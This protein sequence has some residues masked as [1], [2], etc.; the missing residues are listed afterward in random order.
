MNIKIASCAILMMAFGI[1]ASSTYADSSVWKISKDGK[2]FYLGGTMHLLNAQDHP[3]P[4]EFIKAYKDSDKLIFETNMADTKTPEAKQKFSSAMAYSAAKTLKHDLN[5]ET[6][7]KLEQFLAERKIPIENVARLKPWAVALMITMIE[8]Q[9]A[10]M[11]PEYGVEEY[12]NKLAMADNKALGY[13]E[14]IDEQ[15]AFL[16]SMEKIEPNMMIDYTIRDL[17]E[18]PQTVKS[19]KDSW[20][21]GDIDSLAINNS[22]AQMKTEFPEIYDALLVNRNNDWMSDL[23]AL[24]NNDTKEFVLVGALHL[25]GK[26]GLLN[27]LRLAGFKIDQL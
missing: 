12:F 9:K 15:I 1:L 25:S 23:S 16:E 4:K 22:I 6:Y 5:E 2:Y 3:L 17:D 11:M 13:L 19:L 24:N 14:S 7:L 18:L 20:R 10:G 27:Q 21:N 26:E 8:Y